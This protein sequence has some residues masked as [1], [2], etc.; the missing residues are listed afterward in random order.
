M[1]GVADTLLVVNAGSSSIKFQLFDVAA[2]DGL[3]LRVQGSARGHRHQA[4]PRGQGRRRRGAGRRGLP[5]G[6]GSGRCGA[7]LD[8]L[9]ALADRAARRRRRARS[10]TGSS[11]AA[12]TSPRRSWSTTRCWTRLERLVPAGAAAP[13]EQP[14]ADPRRSARGGRTCPRSPASTPRSTAAIPRSPTGSRSPDSWYQ[15]GVRRYGF[16]GLSYEYIAGRLREVDPA[17]AQGR[18]VVCHLGS[19][20]LDVRAPWT[21]AAST[22]RW[23]SPPSTACRWAPAPASSTPASSSTCCRPRAS[24]PARIERFLY[25]EGGLKGLSGISNDVRDLL[26]SDE[27]RCGAARSTTSSTASSARSGALAAAMGGHRRH[28]VHRRHRRAQ[29]GDPRRRLRAAAAGS[30]S[31]STRRAN[32]AARPAASRPPASRLRPTSIP[33]DEERMI[34]R[35][36]LA[37]LGATW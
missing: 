25:H 5:A 11:M 26:A 22:A 30:A 32:A 13:A 7:A 21:A 20:R 23:A 3:E 9:E 16:H 10:A 37:L 34:A 24:T 19:R 2:G 27:P 28:R 17:L 33:T 31:S 14:G 4:A 29:P 8:R 18:V 35:H 15:E 1:T 36:T 12:R 6:R